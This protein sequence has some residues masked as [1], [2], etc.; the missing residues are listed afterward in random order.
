M[1]AVTELRTTAPEVVLVAPLAI[2]N[3]SQGAGLRIRPRWLLQQPFERPDPAA[4][5]VLRGREDHEIR[6]SPLQEL[7]AKL[8]EPYL[9]RL[10]VSHAARIA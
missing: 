9:D 6:C 10:L 5:F 8:L 2:R 7:T 3:E 1:L 4:E